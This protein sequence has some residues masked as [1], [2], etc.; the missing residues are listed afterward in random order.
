MI[1]K[2]TYHAKFNSTGRT[3]SNHLVFKPGI[4][5]IQ[6]EN[7]SGKSFVLEMIRYALFGS[8]ALRGD[9]SDYDKLE[10]T[11]ECTI[12]N[13]K[14][15]IVR[16]DGKAWVNKNEAVGTTATNN[17][18]LGVLG[19]PLSVFDI[20]ANAHQGELTKLTKTMKPTERRRM[21]DSV[22][23]LDQFEEVEKWS[24]GESNNFK[25]LAES[26]QAQII[27]P[28]E[29]TKPKNY[30][31][32]FE[33]QKRLDLEIKNKTLKE[34][35]VHMDA[36]KLPTNPPHSLNVLY[37]HQEFLKDKAIRDRLEQRLKSLPVNDHPYTKDQ[38]D[39][40]ETWLDQEALGPQ[41]H[42]YSEVEL[43]S[44]THDHL[45]LNK[46]NE[47]LKCQHCGEIVLGEELPKTPPLSLEEIKAELKAQR[48]WQG[49]T[50][51]PNLVKSELSLAE[52]RSAREALE[53]DEER[54]FLESELKN[55][56][57]PPLD[58]SKEAEE[59]EEYTKEL[60]V[61]E[62][63]LVHYQNYLD[64]KAEID[65]LPDPE[66]N[67]R[68]RL[69]ECREYETLLVKYEATLELQVEQQK[70]VNEAL[71]SK[72]AYQK[73]GEAL[74][75]VRLDIKRYVIP[76]LSKVSSGLLQ[77]MTNGQR[78]S[79]VIDED[80]EIYVDKQPVRT[81]SGSGESATNLALRIALGQVLTQAVLPIFLADEI[82]A[83][84][85]EKRTEATHDSL[86]KLK[87]RLDQIIIVTHKDF[88]EGDEYIWI[89]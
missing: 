14:Y 89:T 61:Y 46:G 37:Q 76:A 88:K 74:K 5:I 70:K 53:A 87:S 27:A 34:S 41:P 28:E 65:A 72:E 25:R 43:E 69:E 23:G 81:L 86:R 19:F 17:F 20:C 32:S 51:N 33:L 4:T 62:S 22:L 84:M 40:F 2:L 83:D 50:F 60:L 21:V 55:L 11:L 36:P 8:A 63:N 13:K 24:R 85:A 15:I 52:I 42:G 68:E 26:L 77:E 10:V 1:E 79:I 44:W 6:G 78:R 80:F 75:E 59:L 9:K 54:L 56:G 30:E 12:K 45:I 7:E 47:P 64:R 66:P 58:V 57:D 39:Q 49:K 3:I 48:N 67:L 35:F 82:D 73:G 31:S 71:A 29:P 38:L 18:I 16:K